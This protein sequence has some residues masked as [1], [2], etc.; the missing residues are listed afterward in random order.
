MN[1]GD[2]TLAAQD[3]GKRF[4][5]LGTA[6]V[7]IPTYNEAENIKSIVGRVR[8]AVPDAHVL[9]ADDN[10]P[11]GTGKL[12]DELA[13][14]D[15]HVQVLHRKGKEGLGAAYLAGFRW[16]IEHDYGVLIEMDADGSHQPEELPRLLTALK[17]ADLV[18]GSRWVPGGRVVN[19][20][21]SREFISRGGS[22]YSRVALDLPLRDITGGYRAFRRETLQG[23]GLDDVASQGYCFQVDLARRAVKA[24]YHVVEV[25]IT[26]VERE[27]GDSKMSRDILVE[28]LWRV[29]TWGAQERVGKLLGRAKPAS[30]SQP[31]P[32]PQSQ[33]EQPP[34]SQ[35]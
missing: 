33:P 34:Q 24:G 11:D 6:L 30:S 13:A 28:A 2:G 25:P 15:D 26:F 21:K 22:L 27:L 16:G 3:R 8:K 1:D 18:L 20:P 14:E 5:P 32:R 9:V 10:S 19:W 29:T 35:S 4:G 23:L 12:A 31:E 7:I 17:G